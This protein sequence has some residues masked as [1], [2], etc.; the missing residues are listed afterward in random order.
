M[1][2]ESCRLMYN[3]T[4]LITKE[5]PII[6]N[7]PEDKIQTVLFL[8]GGEGRKG[9]GGLRTKG[10]FKHSYKL[11]D[12]KWWI[13]DTDGNPVKEAPEDIQEKIKNY[14]STLNTE[15]QITALPLITVITVVLNGEKYLEETIQSVI[16]QTYP[17]VEYIIVDGG[18]TDGTL[19]I[20]KKYEDK[21]DYWVSEKDNG[22]YD[23]MN[24]GIK[25]ASGEWINFMN[26]GDV[27]YENTILEK[28]FIFSRLD[29]NACVLY[30]DT[31]LQ[32]GSN[33]TIIKAKVNMRR[34]L[35]YYHQ[36]SFTKSKILKKYPFNTVYKIAADYEQ[37]LRFKSMNIKMQY[38][39][40][41]ISVYLGNGISE[42]FKKET[43][44]ELYRAFKKN[45]PIYAFMLYVYRLIKLE[46]KR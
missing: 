9:E 30:G 8:P 20:I 26:A 42:A 46:L 34:R 41:A 15:I 13:C 44:K 38:V 35:P 24:K 23:A 40:L 7:H 4:M 6:V 19:D 25:V 3:K 12:G 5:V 10:Y 18:S 32:E 36:S 1:V 33:Y 29:Q 43:I 21:I 45:N 28:L 2:I 39:P 22:I 14:V 11:A 27:F 16:N 37:F 17:N 31:L